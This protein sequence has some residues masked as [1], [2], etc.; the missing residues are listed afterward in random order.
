MAKATVPIDD[1]VSISGTVGTVRRGI[2]P[3]TFQL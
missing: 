1:M 2:Y 3:G